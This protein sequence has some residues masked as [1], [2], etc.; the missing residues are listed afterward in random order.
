MLVHFIRM[1]K[2]Y[3]IPYLSIAEE[4]NDAAKFE[5]LS[6]PNLPHRYLSQTVFAILPTIM[7]KIKEIFFLP[8]YFLNKWSFYLFYSIILNFSKHLCF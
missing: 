6:L 2:T 5:R 7:K 4:L 8:L 1:R 3:R